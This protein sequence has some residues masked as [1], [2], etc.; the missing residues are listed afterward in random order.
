MLLSGEYGWAL[1]AETLLHFAAR[2]DHVE[3]VIRPALA[4]GEWVVS[5]RFF[6][7]TMAYQGF[8]QGADRGK[9]AELI[10]MLEMTP[11]LTVMLDVPIA[12]SV[13]RLA[14]RAERADRYE[15]LG[16]DFFRRVR[17][18]F[19]AIARAE[20]DRCVVIDADREPEATHAAVWAA[21]TPAQGEREKLAA[22]SPPGRGPG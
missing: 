7:S 13:A 6:D 19:L 5:D 8:G 16:P 2:A 15:R 21:V 18:G 14:H 10:A 20:P 17:D 9:I 1:P 3:Q 12:V 22:P 4:R 11:D